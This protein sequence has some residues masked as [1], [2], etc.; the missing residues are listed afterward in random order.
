MALMTLDPTHG[1]MVPYGT[2]RYPPT[3]LKSFLIPIPRTQDISMGSFIS[4]GTA[5]C[6]QQRL[7]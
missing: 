6:R 1:Q 4:T 7:R 3:A 2:G 5:P